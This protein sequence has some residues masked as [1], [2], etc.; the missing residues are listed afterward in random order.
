MQILRTDAYIMTATFNVAASRATSAVATPPSFRLLGTEPIRAALEYAD[1]QIKGRWQAAALPK[2]DRHPVIIFPGLASSGKAVAPLRQF[3]QS[4]GYAA[5]DWGKGYNTGPSGNPH[6]WLAELAEHVA[7][8]LESH[9]GSATLIGWSLGGVYARELGKLL[10]PKI[11]QVIT[12]GTPFNATANQTH[13]GWLLRLLSGSNAKLDPDLQQQLKIPPPVPTTSIYSRSDGIV[14]WETCRHAF[15]TS[16]VEDIEI[17]GSHIG[18][19]WN[20]AVMKVVADRLSQQPGRWKPY[21]D[22]A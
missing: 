9:K 7:S 20:R 21:A 18:M 4:L 5:F 14:A 10:T 17:Q 3:C 12:I 1:Y 11:R 13:V 19:G 8:L 2:G 16:W 6:R 22:N 15:P